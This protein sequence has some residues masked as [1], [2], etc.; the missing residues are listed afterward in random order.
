MA[1]LLAKQNDY[2]NDSWA[3][4][5]FKTKMSCTSAVNLH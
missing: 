2:F 4:L 5:F 3:I 1:P